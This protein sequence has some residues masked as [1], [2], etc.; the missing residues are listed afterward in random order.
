MALEIP[1]LWVRGAAAGGVGGWGTSSGVGERAAGE[2]ARDSDRG[3]EEG[4]LK[5]SARFGR[6]GLGWGVISFSSFQ[7][8]VTG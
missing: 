2:V 3:G 7:T 1:R 4:V 5:R 6:S 8:R